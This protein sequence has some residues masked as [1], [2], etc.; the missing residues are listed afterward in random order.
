MALGDS[1]KIVLSAP[2]SASSSPGS[3]WR[4]ILSACRVLAGNRRSHQL[5]GDAMTTMEARRASFFRNPG[6]PSTK[7]SGSLAGFH[8]ASSLT[9]HM[10][11]F[12][13]LVNA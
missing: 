3:T 6:N 13:L 4:A 11:G 10:H 5:A 1:T 12:G 7:P 2:K 9:V 8:R